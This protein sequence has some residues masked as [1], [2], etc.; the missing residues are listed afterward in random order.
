MK[1]IYIESLQNSYD[2]N[3]PE[4]GPQKKSNYNTQ[5]PQNQC[6]E[7]SIDGTPSCFG[8]HDFSAQLE[9]ACALESRQL[10]SGVQGSIP[11]AS[12][13]AHTTPSYVCL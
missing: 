1:K 7:Q 11:C 6:T 8:F 12:V 2:I 5:D 4:G 10:F 13:R 9:L 3:I